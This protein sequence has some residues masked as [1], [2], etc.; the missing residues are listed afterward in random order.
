MELYNI[1][2]PARG[3]GDRQ[4]FIYF[5]EIPFVSRAHAPSHDVER[6]PS[7]PQAVKDNYTPI[8]HT[9]ERKAPFNLVQPESGGSRVAIGRDS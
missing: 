8:A 6:M 3:V 5:D 9:C 1:V 2:G 7:R 4:Y